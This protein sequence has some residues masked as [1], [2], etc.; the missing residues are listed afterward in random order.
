MT[1]YSK[2]EVEQVLAEN[3][4]LKSELKKL[5]AKSSKPK[6]NKFVS[7]NLEALAEILDPNKPFL[8]KFGKRYYFARKNRTSTKMENV[9]KIPTL[10]SDLID[11]KILLNNGVDN[12]ANRRS[13][14]VGSLIKSLGGQRI[15]EDEYNEFK[16]W[17]KDLKSK[18]KSLESQG[19]EEENLIKE[20]LVY[21]SLIE[22]FNL[23][24]LGVAEKMG[25]TRTRVTNLLRLLNFAIGYNL[26]DQPSQPQDSKKDIFSDS[27]IWSD[28]QG[29]VVK[30]SLDRSQFDPDH[31]L[32]K[33]CCITL[34]EV[35]YPIKSLAKENQTD[36]LNIFS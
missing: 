17:K 9:I 32:T 33:D 18:I 21:Q 8:K 24:Q 20:A 7:E 30:G 2:D 6:E 25:T 3:K 35:I 13:M 28:Q 22:E 14:D 1:N 16:L 31:E 36:L 27:Y 19:S 26:V 5:V 34:G 12:V 4:K 15:N 23:T 11:A 10:V 29:K